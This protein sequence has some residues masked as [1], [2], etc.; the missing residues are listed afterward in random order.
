M[1]FYKALAL[2]SMSRFEEAITE[3]ETALQINPADIEI[4]NS[5]GV[6]Y[7]RIGQYDLAI[8]VFERIQ[9]IDPAF[10]PCYCNRIITYTECSSMI[11]PSRCFTSLSK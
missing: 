7:T 3:Y 9:Q 10:E 6:D 2:D 5:L 8:D 4:L 1:A 11:M